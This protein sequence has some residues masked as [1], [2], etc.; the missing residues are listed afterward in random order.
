VEY[1]FWGLLVKIATEE[2]VEKGE[3]NDQKKVNRATVIPKPVLT[4]SAW[5]S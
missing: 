4:E 3:E 1:P 2:R 5:M